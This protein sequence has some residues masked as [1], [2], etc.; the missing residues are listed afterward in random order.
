MLKDLPVCPAGS[1]DGQQHYS[2]EGPGPT[3]L[4]QALFAGDRCPEASVVD[5]GQG[6]LSMKR[7]ALRVPESSSD[8][9]SEALTGKK[10]TLFLFG[11]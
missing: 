10:G 6:P 1:G 8:F 2:N 9:Q 7:A 5:S 4:P 3:A 11:S